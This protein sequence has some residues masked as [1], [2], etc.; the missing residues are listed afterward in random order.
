MSDE[1]DVAETFSGYTYNNTPTDPFDYFEEKGTRKL[2]FGKPSNSM[3][4]F[5][6]VVDFSPE[7]YTIIKLEKELTEE[8]E[9][10]GTTT[11]K[12]Y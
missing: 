10:E 3:F 7:N 6:Y 4:S 2:S 8:E 11:P 9:V 12:D 5:D 1:A